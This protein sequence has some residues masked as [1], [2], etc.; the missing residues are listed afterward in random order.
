MA[1]KTKK[2]LKDSKQKK[3]TI[4]ITAA[5]GK[6]NSGSWTIWDRRNYEIKNLQLSIE[7]LKKSID[8]LEKKIESQGLSGYFSQN[9][10]CMRYTE[11]VWRSCL[12]LALLRQLDEETDD[13]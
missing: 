2:K 13:E 10:D 5:T 7:S 8:D 9:H 1:V 4:N 11:A 12:K 3:K 6:D